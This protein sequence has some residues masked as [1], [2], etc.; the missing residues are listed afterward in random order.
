MSERQITQETATCLGEAVRV[1]RNL[2]KTEKFKMDTWGDI[3]PRAPD[4][5][6]KTAACVAG[7]CGL[8]RWFTSRG[9]ISEKRP[10]VGSLIMR[11]RDYKGEEAVQKFF[12]LTYKDTVLL[13]MP[14]PN[15]RDKDDV[16]VNFERFVDESTVV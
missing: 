11:Y 6:C 1:L 9:L 8:D 2:D 5:R 7:W 14:C 3:D 4:M 13:F 15:N 10:N 12:G 16:I